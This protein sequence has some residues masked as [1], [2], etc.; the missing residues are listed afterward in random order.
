MGQQHFEPFEFKGRNSFVRQAECAEYVRR[1]VLPSRVQI[2]DHAGEILGIFE[3]FLG[4]LIWGGKPRM[5]QDRVL[6]GRVCPE[7]NDKLVN[8]SA[9][10]RDDF[11]FLWIGCTEV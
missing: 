10:I 11:L 6:E 1:D 7:A 9:E 8:R 5:L 4:V 2:N 3:N